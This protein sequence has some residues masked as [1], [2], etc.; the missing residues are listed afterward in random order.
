MHKFISTPRGFLNILKNSGQRIY[1]KLGGKFRMLSLPA[2]FEMGMNFSKWFY[3]LDDDILTVTVY[4]ITQ[5]PEIVVKVSSKKC[6]KDV[7]LCL[8]TF[9]PPWK[10]LRNPDLLEK[11]V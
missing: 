2:V 8:N 3:K 10:T 4:T 5:F 11:P 7:L 1:V 9:K 6:I